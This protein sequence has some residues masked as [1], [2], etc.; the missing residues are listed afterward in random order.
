MLE[1]TENKDFDKMSAR[2]PENQAKWHIASFL[3]V[4]A[5][6]DPCLNIENRENVSAITLNP[7]PLLPQEKRSCLSPSLHSS[8]IFHLLLC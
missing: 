3:R 5:N 1:T 7:P 4:Q 6:T 8:V 2:S